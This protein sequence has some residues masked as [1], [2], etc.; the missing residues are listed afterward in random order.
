M[1]P[2][3]T[4]IGGGHVGVTLLAEFTRTTGAH[5]LHP[6]LLYRRADPVESK[7]RIA[8]L[9]RPVSFELLP[10][11]ER[12]TV[13]FTSDQFATLNSPRGRESLAR[14]RIIVV[15]VPD[16]PRARI[17]LMDLLL[18]EVPLAGKIIVL[19]RAGQAGQPYVAELVRTRRELRDT[20]LVLVED[21]F[22][23]TRVTNG[24][25]SCKRKL[26]VNVAVYAADPEG[27]VQEL[28]RLFPSGAKIGRPSWPDL[29]LRDGIEL[30]FDPLGYII[31]AGVALHP[32]NLRRTREGTTYAHYTEGI[33]RALAARL[34]R[35][36]RERVELAR[37]Y[38]VKTETFPHI[39]QRQ[40]GL[41]VLDD[42]FEMMQS[43]SSIYRSRSC[44]SLAELVRSRMIQEDIPPVHTM[45]RLADISG[46][47]LPGTREHTAELG[48]ALGTLGLRLD[49][50]TGYL[51]VLER[52]PADPGHLIQLLNDP[53]SFPR[54]VGA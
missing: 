45:S 38:G 37:A 12:D 13:C 7:A 36:D 46:T 32:E 33:D 19:V 11:G 8:P 23:G 30:I 31:H 27:I 1:S 16:I 15:T 28:R 9:R 42:F 14:A 40:Y 49:D 21:S 39:I 50:F 44:G 17:E 29:I 51:P 20:A 34:D 5:G 26:E 6:V 53:R 22:H 4:I 41:P 24:E 18:R 43:C 2:L 25:I 3:I 54:E 10:G 35:V 48:R 47:D 52:I